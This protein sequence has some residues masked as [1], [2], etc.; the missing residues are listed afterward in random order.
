[1]TENVGNKSINKEFEFID[2]PSYLRELCPGLPRRF[3]KAIQSY[4]TQIVNDNVSNYAYLLRYNINELTYD[5]LRFVLSYNC[6]ESGNNDI[7]TNKVESAF[8]A[9]K[10]VD[11]N[12]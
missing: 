5:L 7:V 10:I 4:L 12:S 3:W 8:I 2:H 1:M 9:S 6:Q 11:L